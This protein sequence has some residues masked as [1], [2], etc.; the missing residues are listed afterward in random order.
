MMRHSS[1]D[2]A[3]STPVV[4]RN[5]GGR[6][7]VHCPHQTPVSPDI[8]AWAHRTAR[9]NARLNRAL[10]RASILLIIFAALWMTAHMATGAA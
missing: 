6:A 4:V 8:P 1:L 5:G 10:D 3:P 2:R 9:S 7:S